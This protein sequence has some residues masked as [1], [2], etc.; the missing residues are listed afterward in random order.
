MQDI[1][2]VMACIAYV[3]IIPVMLTAEPLIEVLFGDDFSRSAA[4][5]QIHIWAFIF[6][7]LGVVRGRWLVAQNYTRFAMVAAMLGALVNVGLNLLLLPDYGGVG[8]AW[9]TLVACLIWKPVR[10]AAV[11][12]MKALVVPFRLRRVINRITE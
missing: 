4:I 12:M 11:Q 6:V 7:A 5:L 10:I 8:A 2:D 9:A 1:Y 3:I